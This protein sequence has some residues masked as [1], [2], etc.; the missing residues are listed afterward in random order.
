MA[1]CII[2]KKD[3]ASGNSLRSHRSRYHKVPKDLT[4]EEE[5]AQ[6]SSQDATEK[7]SQQL[8]YDQNSQS[9]VEDQEDTDE[10]DTDDDLHRDTLS[11]KRKHSE[12]DEEKPSKNRHI[13]KRLSGIHNLLKNHLE[14]KVYGS[15]YCYSL[16]QEFDKLV[17]EWFDNEYKMQEALTEEQY[18]YVNM[19]RS[20]K[21]FSD[22]HMVFNDKKDLKTLMGIFEVISQGPKW[23]QI[24]T[25][26]DPNDKSW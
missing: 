2:C 3:F 12:T 15:L 19:I 23:A 8:K 7:D 16:K 17:P 18:R 21:M 1:H 4:Y 14:D 25:Q 26:T 6:L 13:Y 20:L 5:D 11:S 9:T 22:V 10:E 24:R